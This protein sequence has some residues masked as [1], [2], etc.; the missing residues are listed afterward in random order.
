MSDPNAPSPAAAECASHPSQT[1]AG[2]AMD[3][4]RLAAARL[5]NAPD[6]GAGPLDAASALALIHELHVHRIEL[7]IQNEELRR[8]QE[9]L[10][11][12]RRRYVDLYDLAPVG[13]VTLGGSGLIRESNLAAAT[14]LGVTRGALID[15]PLARF[16]HFEDQDTL[17][18]CRY[19]LFE[20]GER[21]TCELRLRRPDGTQIWAGLEAGPETGPG[22]GEPAGAGGQA[23]W[24]LT[25]SDI[26]ERKRVEE[27]RREEA[28]HK[29]LFIA[30]LGHELR[31]PLA[32][33]R[34]VADILRLTPTL[35]VEQIRHLAAILG[36]QSAHLTRLV[37]DV[38]DVASVRRGTIALVRQPFDLRLAADCAAE[39]VRPLLDERR[40]RLDLVL[41]DTPVIVD[42]DRVR[43]AQAIVNLLRNA[44][45]FSPPGAPVSLSLESADGLAL[46]RVQDLG[47]GIDPRALP[48]LFEPGS[49]PRPGAGGLGLGLALVK[50]L[51]QLHG[52]GVE[53]RSPGPRRGSTFVL[54]LPL[55]S[56][57][58]ASAGP[59]RMI[60]PARSVLVVDDDPD[61]A[62]SCALL[63]RV[64]GQRV[65][66]APDGPAA[67]E[68]AAR[69]CPDLILLDL[70][71][72]GMD[73]VELAQR[74]RATAAGRAARLV[75]VTG[76][77]QES[78]RA[79]TQ[80]AGCD[81]HL[82]KPLGEEALL[83][84]LS[85]C[86]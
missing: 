47:A 77:D 9:E 16:I 56:A 36:R 4:R 31:N 71:L 42:G 64:L 19:R 33:I 48:R 62:Q 8:I 69:L 63:L 26:D 61:V 37:D 13:Y 18:R 23:P 55:S 68:A 85:R 40:Q 24:R 72:P 41:P 49:S 30:T 17:Y 83:D 75:A 84:A 67:L 29:D 70:G 59:V 46:I 81:E 86:P 53:A 52:G 7:E 32:P 66:T 12:S 54:H 60:P 14:L 78:D 34:G 38:L 44:S 21:Q 27:E 65:H 58:L 20:T 35:D 51:A 25:L 1:T 11:V 45:E 80:A 39:Q 73:G 15:Q 50:G 43:L 3:L 57:A 6:S 28:R 76:Y 74:L 10:E 79:R 2:P 22:A 5:R 82:L